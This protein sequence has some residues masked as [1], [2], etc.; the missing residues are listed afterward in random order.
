MVPLFNLVIFCKIFPTFTSQV[1]LPLKLPVVGLLGEIGVN[2]TQGVTQVWNNELGPVCAKQVAV[3]GK[4]QNGKNARMTD[5]SPK[6]VSIN[7]PY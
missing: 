7:L 6:H 2:A 4:A 1:I 3:Q 5:A